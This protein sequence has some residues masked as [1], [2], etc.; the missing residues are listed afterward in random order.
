MQPVVKAWKK[1]ERRGKLESQPCIGHL[2]VGDWKAEKRTKTATEGENEIMK[3]WQYAM[4]HRKT[5]GIVVR[6]QIFA[7]T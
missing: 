7:R 4:R 2:R 1:Q 5:M 3:D 6:G